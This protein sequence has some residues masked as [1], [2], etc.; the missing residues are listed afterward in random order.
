MPRSIACNF[1]CILDFQSSVGLRFFCSS[2]NAR[3]RSLSASSNA[4]RISSC[5]VAI[6]TICHLLPSNVLSATKFLYRH[7]ARATHHTCCRWMST[8][9]RGSNNYFFTCEKPDS[10]SASLKPPDG[11]VLYIHFECCCFNRHFCRT[12]L[13][14]LGLTGEGA[15]ESI[16]P[17]VYSEVF[18]RLL[19]YTSTTSLY[20]LCWRVTSVNKCICNLSNCHAVSFELRV[21]SSHPE[22]PQHGAS[23]PPV[24]N[25]APA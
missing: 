17:D 11:I 23:E 16:Q 14:L 20:S 22:P 25:F 4:L 9:A 3:T 18:R 10:V 13:V 5:I 1:S 15:G 12:L 6:T 19:L 24:N 7:S 8:Y 21:P 2:F